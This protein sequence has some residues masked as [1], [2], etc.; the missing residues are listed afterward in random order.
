M[1]VHWKFTPS[2]PHMACQSTVTKGNAFMS[3]S[4]FKALN[5]R[6]LHRMS[7]VSQNKKQTSLHQ[8]KKI[9]HFFHRGRQKDYWFPVKSQS[10][11]SLQTAPSLSSCIE[12]AKH[13]Q[14]HFKSERAA[15]AYVRSPLSAAVVVT[16]ATLRWGGGGQEQASPRDWGSYMTPWWH[17]FS[18]SARPRST[19]RSHLN[20]IWY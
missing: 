20:T 17:G 2:Q 3:P 9:R 10:W 11:N 12:T 14:A 19:R 1:C 16:G 15:V 6:Q 13:V 7:A 8:L 5:K 4:C 18:E